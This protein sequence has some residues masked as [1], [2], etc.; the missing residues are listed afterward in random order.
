MKKLIYVLPVVALAPLWSSVATAEIS[1]NVA[2]TSDYVWRGVSQN[3]QD[4]ALQGG[5]DYGHDAGF[6]AGVWGSN[7]NFGKASTGLELYAGWEKELESGL[8]IDVG[9]IQFTYHGSSS[10]S[11]NNF[12]EAYLAASFKGFSAKYSVGDEYEDHYQL[13]YQKNFEQ[14]GVNLTYGDYD[15]YSYYKV[16][17]SKEMADLEFALDFW[18]TD[19]DAKRSFGSDAGSRV[20]LSISKEF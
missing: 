18:A 10:A 3:Q 6:Y 5:F 9:V 17:L 19:S 14:F 4:P 8:S 13:G 15:K 20:V 12:K 7:V 16:G 2:L 1:A 11:N